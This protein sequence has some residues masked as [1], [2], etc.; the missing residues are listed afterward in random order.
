VAV[1]EQLGFVIG[2]RL[3]GYLEREWRMQEFVAGRELPDWIELSAATEIAIADDLDTVITRALETPALHAHNAHLVAS[4]AEAEANLRAVD[5]NLKATSEE[6]KHLR[7][8]ISA[9]RS[10][11]SWKVTK[12]L[13]SVRSLTSRIS[14]RGERPGGRS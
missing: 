8:E 2:D 13:R 14:G 6:A 10:T 9:M 1:A 3:D 5:A 7:A 11:T 12:P 4:L